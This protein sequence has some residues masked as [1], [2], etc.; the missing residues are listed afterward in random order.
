MCVSLV[1][2]NSILGFLYVGYIFILNMVIVSDRFLW[3]VGLFDF[4]IIDIKKLGWSLWSIFQL[5]NI[6]SVFYVLLCFVFGSIGL[7]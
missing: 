4:S 1:W 7:D 3:Q 6:N 5:I 2:M